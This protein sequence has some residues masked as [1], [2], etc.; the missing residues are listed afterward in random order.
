[1]KNLVIKI[2]FKPTNGSDKVVL[3]FN[4]QKELNS[5]L[6]KTIGVNNKWHDAF[7]NYSIS[8]IQGGKMLD[9]GSII[10]KD[11]MPYIQFTTLDTELMEVLLTNLSKKEHTFYNL[12]YDRV[13]FQSR[14]IEKY[15]D[16]VQTISPL[17]LVDKTGRKITFKDEHFIETLKK[18]CIDKLAHFGINDDTFDI[19]LRNPEK[20]KTKLVFVGNISN[21][22]TYSSFKVYGKKE[23]RETIYALGLGKST[24]S[25]FG[26]V[27]TYSK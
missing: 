23:T 21:L 16:N 11:T 8:G 5:F 22:C 12:E 10:F 2:Y 7:S 27:M 3:P 20:S 13:E 6:H 17:L 14:N 18:N 15:Y 25:G 4:T 26:A 1:M 19:V 9:P 24:G